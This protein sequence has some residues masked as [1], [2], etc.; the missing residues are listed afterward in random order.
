VSRIV[1]AGCGDVGGALGVRLVA[2]GHEV[3]GVRRH[4]ARLPSPL[5]G[6]AADL[7]EPASL[8]ALP[9]DPEV[10]VY[11]AAA[12]E[13]SEAAYRR[14]YVEGVRNVLAATAGSGTVRL[15]VFIS[16]TAVYG[17]RDGEWVDED[18]P[19][20]PTGFNGR[21]LLEGE[22]LTLGSGLTAAVVRLAGIYGPGRTRL[23]EEVRGGRV[24]CRG[25]GPVY[26]NRIHRDDC[27]GALQHVLGLS[28]PEA[29]WLAVDD[30]PA[31]RN[32][33]LRWLASRLGVPAP[34]YVAGPA[35]PSGKR[36]RNAKLRR[37]GWTPRYPTFREGYETVIEASGARP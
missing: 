35:E 6:V 5:R 32:D 27:A 16:S 31:A 19:T 14:A 4:P 11:A 20:E 30:E 2:G 25:D 22:R 17:Q 15:F 21:L 29:V 7:C 26:T 36:G 1:I 10:I 9:P 12:D 37:S 18:S 3:W 33:V 28:R 23:L 13:R 24:Q 34:A 8:R